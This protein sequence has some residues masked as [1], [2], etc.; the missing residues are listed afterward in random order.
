MAKKAEDSRKKK[1]HAKSFS[2]K[3]TKRKT[4]HHAS[5]QE[6][7]EPVA[8]KDSKE[9]KNARHGTES[10][11]CGSRLVTQSDHRH[12]KAIKIPDA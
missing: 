10:A 3:G 11:T 9:V 1:Q 2:N 4:L 6:I 7:A 8:A 12:V 5:Q